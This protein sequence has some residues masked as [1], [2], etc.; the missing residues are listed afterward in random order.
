M[1][2]PTILGYFTRSISRITVLR[3]LVQLEFFKLVTNMAK[4][5]PTSPGAIQARLRQ[6]R[7]RRNELTQLIDAVE[8]YLKFLAIEPTSI[9][10]ARLRQ[11]KVSGQRRKAA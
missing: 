1:R 3:S 8:R 2:I 10:E 5:S 11:A 4:P 7:R 6:L 9:T